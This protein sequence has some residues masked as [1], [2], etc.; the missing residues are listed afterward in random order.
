MKNDGLADAT[1]RLVYLLAA[2]YALAALAGVAFGLVDSAEEIAL[3]VG[4]LGVGAALLFVGQ[5]YLPP[6]WASAAVISLGAIVGCVQLALTI[7]VPLV[8]AVVVTCAIALARR[9]PAPA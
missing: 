7:V 1:R 9:P 4:F 8:A 2:L 6:G 5:R 3:W